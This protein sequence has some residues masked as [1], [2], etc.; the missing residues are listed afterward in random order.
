MSQLPYHTNPLDDCTQ[1]NDHDATDATAVRVPVTDGPP[2][3]IVTSGYLPVNGTPPNNGWVQ[4]QETFVATGG[5]KYLTIG[6][7]GNN[8]Y[9][10]LPAPP[11]CVPP[12]THAP[13]SRYRAFV[14]VDDVRIQSTSH[15]ECSCSAHIMLVPILPS[16]QEDKC[17]FTVTLTNGGEFGHA[18]N[19]CTVYGINLRLSGSATN[20]FAWN[21]QQSQG[22]VPSD[23]I[24]RDLGTICVDEFYY[25]PRMQF[26][27]DIVGEDDQVLCQKSC[28]AHGCLDQC[29]CLEFASSIEVTP[30]Q[31]GANPCCYRVKLDASPLSDCDQIAHIR[32]YKTNGQVRT[33]IISADYDM[34]VPIGFSGYLYTFCPNQP[35]VFTQNELVEI[36][37]T[38]ASGVIICVAQVP[39]L[40]CDCDCASSSAELL[41][42]KVN[43]PGME[44]CFDLVLS[45][46]GNCKVAVSKIR[47]IGSG[48][49]SLAFTASTGWT[50]AVT[51]Y[52]N[53]RASVVYE[54]SGIAAVI[55][56]GE[57]LVLG[58]ICPDECSVVDLTQV[59]A[60]VTFAK[61]NGTCAVKYVTT[62]QDAI[63]SLPF[64]CDDFVVT[65]VAGPIYNTCYCWYAVY[66]KLNN[67]PAEIPGLSVEVTGFAQHP[68]TGN[69]EELVAYWE[70]TQGGFRNVV[71]K[72]ADGTVLCQKGDATPLCMPVNN[73]TLP[74]SDSSIPPD[75]QY[76]VG[77]GEATQEGEQP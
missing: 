33:D 47:L 34:P 75:A 10:M 23:G 58:R 22:S 60:T 15:V 31:Q 37:F 21:S 66:A 14:F 72:S 24:P 54:K 41:Y 19:G 48:L 29:N 65:F 51:T 46:N 12:Y 45:N 13:Q 53:N 28:W 76:R 36:E 43:E 1:I 50:N 8:G 62:T 64:D 5:E 30:I 35:L 57:E 11:V 39:A 67:C 63:C 7:F 26:D 40:K 17:C 18:C 49:A 38:N 52:G 55:Y 32:M 27:Y 3:Y 20:L 68:M 6:Y 71:L 56:P 74:P 16:P 25:Y 4:V 44:C 69:H 61:P 70:S 77:K 2:G 42:R 73:R 59:D 9:P